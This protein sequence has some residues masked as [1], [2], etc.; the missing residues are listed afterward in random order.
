MLIGGNARLVV[1]CRG[2]QV[3]GRGSVVGLVCME[4]SVCM[5]VFYMC[6]MLR[7]VLSSIL[8]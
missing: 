4:Y 6:C 1:N 7:L 2:G 8:M 5:F 3:T